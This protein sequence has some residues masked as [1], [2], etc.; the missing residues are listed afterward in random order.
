MSLLQLHQRWA[1]AAI[2]AA[3]RAV[4][5]GLQSYSD[6]MGKMR[7]ILAAPPEPVSWSPVIFFGLL[8]LLSLG[9][10]IAACFYRGRRIGERPAPPPG[11]DS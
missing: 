3:T 10:L 7:A 4:D 11:L 6:S 5:D 1:A 8:T 9:L 2:N